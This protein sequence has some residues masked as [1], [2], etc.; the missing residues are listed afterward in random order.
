MFT[1]MQWCTD[2]EYQYGTDIYAG[3]WLTDYETALKKFF[4]H[5]SMKF[6]GRAG[7]STEKIIRFR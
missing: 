6:F 5:I 3:L 1:K 4:L 7:Q 2:K